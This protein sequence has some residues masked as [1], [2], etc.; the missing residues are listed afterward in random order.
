MHLG[1]DISIVILG[2]FAGCF[3][4]REKADQALV[5]LKEATEA[6]HD[7]NNILKEASKVQDKTDKL[8]KHLAKGPYA[9]Q[10]KTKT[11]ES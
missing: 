4:M 2:F 1:L 8:L 7:A 3:Y 11:Q 5:S 10:T 6:L 9:F